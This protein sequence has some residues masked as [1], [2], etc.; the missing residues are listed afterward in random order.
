MINYLFTIF[1]SA[2]LTAG[3]IR[4]ERDTE[5][6]QSNTSAEFIQDTVRKTINV[7]F[8][9]RLFTSFRYADTL[10]KPVFYPV[11]APSGVSVTRGYP[12]DPQQGE[13]TD[14]PH[15]TGLW[16]N[17]GD[18]NG[19]DFWNNSRAIP[20]E[21]RCNY[22]TI[23]C[24]ENSV[25]LNRT[26]GSLQAVCLWIDCRGQ[27]LLEE[28]TM[29]HFTR[30][31]PELY[32]LKRLTRLTA[33]ADTVVFGDSKEG[34]LGIRA[35]RSFEMPS[36]RP[37]VLYDTLIGSGGKPVADPAG[38]NGCY[39]GSNG[40]SGAAVWGTRNSWVTLSAVKEGDSISIAMADH[41]ENHGF[42]SCWHA[43]DYGLFSVNNLGVKSYDP[44]QAEARLM[45][46]KD[47]SITF[48]H[49]LLVKSGGF[50]S[51]KEMEGYVQ[52]CWDDSEQ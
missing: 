39:R 50:L 19:I 16:F 1:Y 45:L 33:L 26:D 30:V 35:A 3:T 23:I 36:A 46:K 47:E 17:Y 8:D 24:S 21:R 22:G 15:H 4:C 18:V 43:R 12:L 34:L 7:L 5:Y 14:H 41:P 52:R 38:V 32:A 20:Q 49:L 10:E 11:H 28:K 42:P 25:T 9:G 31:S 37:A 13:R 48:R 2:V 44:Q 29:Y 27:V 40:L 6:R 51:D